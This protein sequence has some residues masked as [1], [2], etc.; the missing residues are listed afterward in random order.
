MFVMAAIVA[1]E[2][3]QVTV[4]VT[5]LV[6]PSVYVAVAE[7]GCVNPTEIVEFAGFTAILTIVAGPTVR[8]VEEVTVP[9][10]AVMV[11]RPVAALVA[12]PCEPG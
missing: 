12:S 10:V 6:V 9:S 11:A 8:V 5:S 3:D 2:E 4:E 1:P 7:N